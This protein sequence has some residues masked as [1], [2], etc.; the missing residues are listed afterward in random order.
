MQSK[1]SA[2]AR[3]KRVATGVKERGT[4]VAQLVK[5]PTLYFGSGHDL[6][7]LRLGPGSDSKLSM[8]SV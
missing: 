7:V 4:W 3:K 5:C 2:A 8:E 6:M 1:S